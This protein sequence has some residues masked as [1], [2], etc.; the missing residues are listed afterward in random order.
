MLVEIS[1]AGF[2][3][4]HR[5]VRFNAGL[6]TVLGSNGGSN[7]IGK[8]TFLWIIDCAFGG[9]TYH[10][11]WEESV[12]HIGKAPIFFTFLFDDELHYFYRTLDEPRAVCRCDKKGKL[13]DKLTLDRYRKWLL[14]SYEVGCPG[15]SF[16][17]LTSRFD[18]IYGADNTSERA[19]YLQK[20]REPEEKA[21]D[22]LIRL[23]GGNGI[24]EAIAAIEGKLGV[25]ASEFVKKKHKPVDISKINENEKTIISLK[26]RLEKLEQHAEDEE[27]AFFGF[28]TETYEKLSLL[29]KELRAFVQKRNQLKSQ[30]N[31]IS[32]VELYSTEYMQA[33][34]AELQVF[35]PEIK[36]K[37][38]EQI[39]VFHK[40]LRH[41]IRDE[42]TEEIERLTVIISQCDVEIARLRDDIKKSGLAKEMSA[43]TIS[44]C[45]SISRMIDQ[46]KE[47]NDELLRQK[48]LQDAR[49][50]AEKEMKALLK[51]QCD[52]MAEIEAIINQR[53]TEINRTVTDG[54]ETAPSLRIFEDKVMRYRTEGNISEGTAFKSVV[55]YD[56]ALAG[57]FPIPFL[58]HDSN[59]I[60]RIGDDYLE[61]ILKYY[62][63]M[64]KQVFIAYDK[65][66]SVTDTARQILEDTTVLAL[67][68]GKELYG[69]SWTKNT[70]GV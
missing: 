54:R 14:E 18:R 25:K 29:H 42:A 56:L 44:Q 19:P 30:L 6:N 40:K 46:L 53:I 2:A 22:F 60:K 10:T 32:E 64:G 48:A 15:I 67:N 41:I 3:E 5:N 20:P 57:L 59:I 35:F 55:I 49:I 8:S 16:L 43:R 36:L 66:D 68:D 21:V 34:F 4:C 37:P 33:E 17:D 24:L 12:Q 62:R 38:L 13:I 65:A 9:E 63:T 70:Q 27:L 58:I 50:Q 11:I 1:C 23:S 39:E 52:R 7:A 26:E 61:H 69:K 51:R 28:D 47:V 31:A 45:V